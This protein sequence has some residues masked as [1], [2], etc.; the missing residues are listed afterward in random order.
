[1]SSMQWWLMVVL[2]VTHNSMEY[3]L[4]TRK[5]RAQLRSTPE[6]CLWER[7]EARVPP[8]SRHRYPGRRFAAKARGSALRL[9]L[10]ADLRAGLP[11]VA[12]SRHEKEGLRAG[13][14]PEGGSGGCYKLDQLRNSPQKG[15]KVE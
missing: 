8:P 3:L 14:L 11:G 2:V 9:V 7:R 5:Q 6:R 10:R 12:R 4:N 15:L 1:M 13:G